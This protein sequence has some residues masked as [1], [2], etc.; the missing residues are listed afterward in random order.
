MGRWKSNQHLPVHASYR[1]LDLRRLTPRRKPVAHSSALLRDSV[2]L[3]DARSQQLLGYVAHHI[4]H[5]QLSQQLGPLTAQLDNLL[6]EGV[7]RIYP[8]TAPQDERISQALPLRTEVHKMW[9]TC[10]R[11]RAPAPTILQTVLNRWRLLTD[12]RRQSRHIRRV[13]REVK[14]AK[15]LQAMRDLEQAA[16]AADQRKVWQIANRLAP[17]KPQA[18]THLRGE[19]GQI[20]SP[21]EQLAHLIQHSRA[22]FGNSTD[23]APTRRLTRDLN[24]TEDAL[25]HAIGKLPIR[26]AAPTTS[27][28]SAA[29]RLC[30]SLF[31][32]L[33]SRATTQD[34]HIG[35]LG[36]VPALLKDA[37]LC[38]LPKPGKDNSRPD[39][40]RPIGLI[41]PLAKAICSALREQ[42]RP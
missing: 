41:H 1:R 4:A 33:L 23:Y 36:Q 20:L 31:A 27:A 10:R 19:D 30:S 22:K 32:P 6:R 3:R 21:S 29:W 26:K 15:L 39:G 35:S 40:L 5:T 12:F 9:D 14:R 8:P 11:I 17:W 24:L 7:Q 42:L 16:L 38:W 25:A 37:E 34:W 13:T 18:R 2:E 28:P